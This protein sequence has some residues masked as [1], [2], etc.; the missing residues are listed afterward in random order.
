MRYSKTR[1]IAT[2]IISISCF[3][4]VIFALYKGEEFAKKANGAGEPTVKAS[5]TEEKKGKEKSQYSS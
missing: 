4:L 2:T 5:V 1:I 3:I